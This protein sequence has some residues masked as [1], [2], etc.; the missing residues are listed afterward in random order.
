MSFPGF[1]LKQSTIENDQNTIGITMTVIRKVLQTIRK[2]MMDAT[3]NP[4]LN[5]EKMVNAS[6]K[7]LLHM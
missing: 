7:T 2:H 1:N 3:K 4:H 5:Q 6:M